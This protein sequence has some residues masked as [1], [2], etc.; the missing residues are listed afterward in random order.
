VSI[1]ALGATATRGGVLV[2]WRTYD[3][4][5]MLAFDVTRS[6]A[7]GSPQDV[8]PD[9][10]LAHGQDLGATYTVT[11]AG[12]T[13][14][15]A[16]TYNLYGIDDTL[17]VAKLGSVTVSVASPTNGATL[18]ISRLVVIG[19]N[20]VLSWTGGQPPYAVEQSS[21]LGA[22]ASWQEVGSALAGTQMVVP[23]TNQTGFF[24]VRGSQ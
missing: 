9:Y 17:L 23:M 13:T 6:T 22:D 14:P 8:T 20:A 16:Y 19:G 7:G 24:R 10:V 21:S 15:G 18:T 1:V 12:A 11:D 5:D 4:L 2:T 3:E